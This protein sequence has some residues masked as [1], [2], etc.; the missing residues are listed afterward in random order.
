MKSF[1]CV[2]GYFRIQSASVLLL[3]VRFVLTGQMIYD[4]I[5][6]YFNKL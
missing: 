3:P 2:C 4:Q 6:V 1:E 5:T